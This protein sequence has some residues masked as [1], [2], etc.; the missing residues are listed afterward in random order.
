MAA[1]RSRC[2]ARLGQL[3]PPVVRFLDHG[4][5]GSGSRRMA[6]ARLPGLDLRLASVDGLELG[7]LDLDLNV[8]LWWCG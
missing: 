8:Q 5:L 7:Q 6:E 2:T 1:S 3:V 4:L